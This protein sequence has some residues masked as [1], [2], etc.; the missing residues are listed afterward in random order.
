VTNRIGPNDRRVSKAA[1]VRPGRA[2]DFAVM[3]E[4]SES[5]A[6]AMRRSACARQA[7]SG[8]SGSR[9]HVL[10]LLGQASAASLTELAERLH[11]DVSSASALVTRLVDQGLATRRPRGDDHRRVTIGLTARG[12][13]AVG[14][15]DAR[16]GKGNLIRATDD[17]KDAELHL[18]A[19]ALKKLATRCARLREADPPGPGETHEV[20]LPIAALGMALNVT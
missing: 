4:A 14:R 20:T 6:R 5:L 17:L 9:L 10:A 1:R 18:L 2:G 7:R 19:A 3:L 11:V 13:S 15:H 8:L 12:R 16:V